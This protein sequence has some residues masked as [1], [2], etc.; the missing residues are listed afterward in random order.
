MGKNVLSYA[1]HFHCSC[2]ATW[3]PCKTSIEH[4]YIKIEIHY[5]HW[6]PPSPTTT[7]VFQGQWTQTVTQNMVKSPFQAGDISAGCLQV[8]LRFELRTAKNNQL[9]TRVGVE[10]VCDLRISSP[11]LYSLSHTALTTHGSL[12]WLTLSLEWNIKCSYN[13]TTCIFTKKT[14]LINF[15]NSKF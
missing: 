3:L 15:C 11:T 12:S 8:W 2:H 5:F 10:P 14:F 4:T 1:K 7:G 13:Y 6:S 9:V